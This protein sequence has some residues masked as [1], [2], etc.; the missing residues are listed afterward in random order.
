MVQFFLKETFDDLLKSMG[1]LGN[2]KVHGAFQ[3]GHFT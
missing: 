2:K 3:V 1:F